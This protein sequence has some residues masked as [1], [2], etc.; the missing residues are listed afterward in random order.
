MKV[1]LIK[2]KGI[3]PRGATDSTKIQTL[4]VMMVVVIIVILVFCNTLVVGYCAHIFPFHFWPHIFQ[5]RR[6]AK[7]SVA[8]AA[9]SSVLVGLGEVCTY[10]RA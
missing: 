9:Q 3:N 6:D 4:V 2:S 10:V 5:A 8:A 7:S 1:V